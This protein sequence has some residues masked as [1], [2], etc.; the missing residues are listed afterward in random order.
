MRMVKVLLSVFLVLTLLGGSAFA[1]DTI[2]IGVLAPLTGF[3]A[4][5]GESVLNSVNIA[6]DKIN[7]SGGYWAKR[8]SW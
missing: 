6:V 7:A 5:D 1:A 8:L 2:K 4:A 3:A